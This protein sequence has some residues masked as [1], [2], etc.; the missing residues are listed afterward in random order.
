MFLLFLKDTPDFCRRRYDFETMEQLRKCLS[1]I[2]E[3]YIGEL[4]E[5]NYGNSKEKRL[6]S[7]KERTET[8]TAYVVESLS[9]NG[10]WRSRSVH[11]VGDGIN[12]EEA[13]NFLVY[14]GSSY[15][16]EAELISYRPVE[17]GEH[18]QI[19]DYFRNKRTGEYGPQM[20]PYDRK[21]VEIKHGLFKK[22]VHIRLKAFRDTEGAVL[23][24]YSSW[25]Q[26]Y[27]KNIRE[28]AFELVYDSDGNSGGKIP[29]KKEV[30]TF[31]DAVR[32]VSKE[33]YL[34]LLNLDGNAD[35]YIPPKPMLMEIQADHFEHESEYTWE[36]NYGIELAFEECG[37]RIDRLYR[38]MRGEVDPVETVFGV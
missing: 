4:R 10:Y 22:D 25:S 21:T 36:E 30:G 35:Q 27:A 34:D 9:P 3:Q 13:L 11:L 28:G 6:P 19:Y 17:N 1:I 31:E 32:H 8:A 16:P 23:F 2:P 7:V 38:E 15:R 33:N 29:F 24:R 18:I 20:Y 26:C 5:K 37:K 12:V 14:E